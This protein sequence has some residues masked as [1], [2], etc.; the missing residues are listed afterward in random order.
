MCKE[1]YVARQKGRLM[2][3][4]GIDGWIKILNRTEGYDGF[5]WEVHFDENGKLEWVDVT[6]FSKIRRHPVT[7][8][9]Y[10]SEYV[11]MGGFVAGQMPSHMLRLFSLRHAAR[12]FTPLGANV[13]TEDEARMMRDHVQEEE[14]KEETQPAKTRTEAARER[15]AKAKPVETP[16]EKETEPEKETADPPQDMEA[17]IKERQRKA[18]LFEKG[19]EAAE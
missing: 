15:A 17:A 13:I 1:V 4:V 11:K 19:H 14:R 8:R 3:I 5:D 2:T 7:Y 12:L 16:V 18:G 9:G 6:I 10:W